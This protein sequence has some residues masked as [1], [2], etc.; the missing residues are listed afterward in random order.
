MSQRKG[1]GTAEDNSESFAQ[2]TAWPCE[3]MHDYA[4]ENTLLPRELIGKISR[5]SKQ[6]S[7]DV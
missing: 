6:C 3:E 2:L 1:T 5:V 4:G 7:Y